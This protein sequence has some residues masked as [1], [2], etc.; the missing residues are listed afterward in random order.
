MLYTPS[1]QAY[2]TVCFVARLLKQDFI[3]ADAIAKLRQKN[4]NTVRTAE[5]DAG[6]D[7]STFDYLVDPA[8]AHAISSHISPLCGSGSIYAREADL[9]FWAALST[10][11]QALQVLDAVQHVP[12]TNSQPGRCKEA[13]TS[14]EEHCLCKIDFCIPWF[15]CGLK[16]RHK[17]IKTISIL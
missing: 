7:N 11:A 15:P 10:Q 14:Q 1:I 9:K 2:Q 13:P 16:Y 12:M 5:E 6:R 8:K 17:L 3:A 4:P